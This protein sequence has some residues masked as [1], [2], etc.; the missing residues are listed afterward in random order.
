MRVVIQRVSRASC[1]VEGKITGQIGQGLCLFV[2]FCQ[3]DD[4]SILPKVIRKI[5]NLRIFSDEEGKMN[6][7]V[8]SVGGK[9]LSI[10]QFTLYASLA[11]GMR[12]G[13]SLAAKADKARGLYEKFNELLADQ[14]EVQTGI[15]QADMKIDLLNDGPVT[16]LLDSAE[17]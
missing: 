9:I 12:P 15:F 17:L 11:K 4:E 14:I 8:L 2:G 7:S 16:I 13:F 1:M 10:S 6:L 5:V 3:E